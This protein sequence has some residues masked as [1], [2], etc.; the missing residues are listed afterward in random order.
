MRFSLGISMPRSLAMVRCTYFEGLALAL[1]V[2]RIAA[3]NTDGT[4]A[5]DDAAGFAKTFDGGTNLHG[6]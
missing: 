5:A 1:L 4:L 3:H 6:E 2:T